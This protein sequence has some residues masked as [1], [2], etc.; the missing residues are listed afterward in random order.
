MEAMPKTIERTLCESETAPPFHRTRRISLNYCAAYFFRKDGVCVALAYFFPGR[1]RRLFL[2][3]T[4]QVCSKHVNDTVRYGN[5]FLAATVHTNTY[6][7]TYVHTNTCILTYVHTNTYIHT[8]VHTNTCILTYVHTHTYKH[9]YVHT[10]THMYIHTLT[11]THMYIQTLA[12]THM[13]IH[14]LTYTHMYIHTYVH[15]HI[16]TYTHLH[17]HICTY[18]HL[19]THICTYTHMSDTQT[20]ICT[21]THLQTHIHTFIHDIHSHIYMYYCMTGRAVQGNIPFEI[22]RIS[23]TEGRD[24]T[25]IENAIFPCIARPEELQ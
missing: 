18:T 10:N 22:D 23:P 4:L 13:Y 15:T 3:G 11:N 2:P 9:T 20:H 6:I 16:C 1:V 17:T 8:C 24:D 5:F 14:T 21:Y 25:E 12:Y 7:H 19:H